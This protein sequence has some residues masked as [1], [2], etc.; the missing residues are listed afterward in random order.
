[1]VLGGTF[2][3]HS[4]DVGALKLT[5]PFVYPLHGHT[6]DA[7]DADLGASGVLCALSSS[8]AAATAATA[9]SVGSVFEVKTSPVSADEF[10]PD[11]ESA[12]DA[13]VASNAT[14]S[15][16]PFSGHTAPPHTIA[17]VWLV[18]RE[19]ALGLA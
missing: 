6:V 8:P 14:T 16:T 10:H 15:T 5:V 17:Q 4:V 13:A 3:A 12:F 1:V 19:L 7:K 9:A 18:S 11:T 2:S